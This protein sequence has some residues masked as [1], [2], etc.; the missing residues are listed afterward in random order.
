MKKIF[1]NLGESIPNYARYIVAFA[2][3]LAL[4][5]LFPTNATFKYRFGLGQTWLYD[6]LIANFD[7][8]IL[9][10]PEE[11]AKER[12]DM[13]LESSPYYEIDL[14]IIKERKKEFA[15]N[16]EI[17]L[18]RSRNQFPDVARNFLHQALTAFSS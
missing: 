1:Q 2:T 10:T 17:Q 13:E 6:D 18:H 7:F 14:D 3:L 11:L 5:P 4:T 8:A 12:S 9:K 16:F 15:E